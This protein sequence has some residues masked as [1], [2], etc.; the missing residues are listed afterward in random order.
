MSYES[1][2]LKALP[3]P[4]AEIAQR[5]TCC[6]SFVSLASLS[7]SHTTQRGYS[8]MLI[9]TKAATPAYGIEAL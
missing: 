4:I 5:R 1:L 6:M 7:H 9:I 8:R 3:G 2:S